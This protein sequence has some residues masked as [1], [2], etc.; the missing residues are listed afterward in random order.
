MNGES[1]QVKG[2]KYMEI[3]GSKI[4]T[5]ISSGQKPHQVDEWLV[6][7]RVEDRLCSHHH[8][9]KLWLTDRSNT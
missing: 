8:F 1:F 3:R 5:K 6:N 9:T 7:N 4:F 2:V